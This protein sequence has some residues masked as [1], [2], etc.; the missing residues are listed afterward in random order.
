MEGV[1]YV[2]KLLVTADG[3]VTTSAPALSHVACP[4]QV[5]GGVCGARSCLEPGPKMPPKL[6]LE[7][8]SAVADH[9]KQVGATLAC[10]NS[11]TARLNILAVEPTFLA[12]VHKATQQAPDTEMWKLVRRA[13]GTHAQFHVGSRHG[14]TSGWRD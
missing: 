3:R 1:L 6:V 8:K 12:W 4:C 14:V 13:C 2:A 10:S 5:N 7:R 11:V 9:D